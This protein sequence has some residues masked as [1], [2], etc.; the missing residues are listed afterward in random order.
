MQMNEVPGTGYYVYIFEFF[1]LF[2]FVLFVLIK[3]EDMLFVLFS[4]HMRTRD[5]R[6]Y[7][8]RTRTYMIHYKHYK[9]K[10]YP[11]PTDARANDRES[12][13]TT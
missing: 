8:K 1:V 10:K 2:L 11:K 6:Y 13:N 5:V 9:S 3:V 4:R 7:F 12:K